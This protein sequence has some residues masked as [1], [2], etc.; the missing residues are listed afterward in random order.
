MCKRCVYVKGDVNKGVL[1]S[2]I[3]ITNDFCVSGTGVEV[4]DI[5]WS[6]GRVGPGSTG[7]KLAVLIYCL[8]N[9]C[10]IL[11]PVRMSVCLSASLLVCL[12]VC[13]YVF[14]TVY[15]ASSQKS[16]VQTCCL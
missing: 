5:S 13:L 3:N 7:A 11:L 8:F 6:V 12:P 4:L 9:T 14:H 10:S 1:S 16:I 15:T 2:Q